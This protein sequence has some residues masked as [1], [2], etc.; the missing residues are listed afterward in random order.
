[1]SKKIK[2][3][4]KISLKNRA[5]GKI[6]TGANTRLL[7]D[8]K[9]LKSVKSVTIK[10]HARKLTTVIIEMYADVDFDGMVSAFVKKKAKKKV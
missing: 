9:P 2:A 7:L 3:P 6:S 8:G 10:A 1:M 5:P 4:H